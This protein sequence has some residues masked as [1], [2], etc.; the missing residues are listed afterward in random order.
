[1]KH[2]LLRGVAL[3]ATLL[4]ISAP[5]GAQADTSAGAYLAGRH[6]LISS[7]FAEA[8]AY[9]T[10][11][12][13]RDRQ[14]PHLME[15]VVLSQFALGKVDKAL[16]VAKHMEQLGLHSQVAHLV[17]ITDLIE[18]GK[19]EELLARD[20]ETLGG[21]PLVD[22]L[23]TGWAHMGAGSVARALEQFDTVS[24]QKGLRGF[25][26]YH[27]ALALASVGDFEGAEAIFAD[28]SSGL[29]ILSRGAAIA[30]A[31]ILSQLERNDDATAF[32]ENAFGT[33]LDPGLQDVA[34]RL[35][36]GEQL[37]FSLVT[38]VRDGMAEV[39]FSIGQALNGEA[40]DDYV[41][42]YARTATYLRPGHVDSLLLSAQLLDILGQYDLA[43]ATYKQIPSDSP[44]Y[45][46]AE[47]GRAEALRRAAKPDAAIEVL[48]RLAADYPTLAPVYSAL[49]DLQRQQEHYAEAITAYDSALE[50]SDQEAPARWFLHYAR[51]ISHERLKQWDS[52]EA[53]FRS[54]LEINPDQPQVLNYLGYSL[55]E[56][57]SNLDEALG[58]IERAVEARP[59]SGYI[60]D[61][62]GWV[63]FR[64][65]RYEEAVGHMETAVELMPVD[66]VVND[67]LGDV[68]WAVGRYREAE[69]Q[70][71]R[72]I[73]FI[74]PEDTDSEADPERIRRKLEI[75][76]DQV[77]VEEGSEP[78]KV[79]NDQG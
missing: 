38:S 78:L 55:V 47:M 49:G 36:A 12:L 61:S 37:P 9:Y 23:I 6:A 52:A 41:L 2:S 28:E 8:A 25:A 77:L 69:F 20:P 64:L 76:L 1:M 24:R 66:P 33:T 42:I 54:A 7:D 48:E 59:D 63:L 67:H 46:A 18:N 13:A 60:V 44:D 32:L 65:G 72:A 57:K 39:F 11:A 14:N 3:A 30:R 53:D 22:G 43:V 45:H 79:V 35:A 50:F 5:I 73:S 29:S 58:M 70:W 10:R 27:K 19:Y 74:D 51:G 75:G 62:L 71:K 21:G 26:L 16:P 40:S 56:R 17:V 31:Q 4:A 34:D 15:Q 68:Y